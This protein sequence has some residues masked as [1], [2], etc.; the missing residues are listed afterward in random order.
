MK[1]YYWKEKKNFGDLL[2]S[3]LIKHF[4]QLSAV[5]SRPEDAAL[6]MVGS[7]LHHFPKIWKGIVAGSGKL[8]ESTIIPAGA[9]ILA[10]RGPLSA[11]GV[12]HDVGLGDPGL[13]ADEL[14]GYQ[15]KQWEL[16]VVPHWSD[17]VLEYNPTFLK[18]NPKIIRVS[19]DPLDVI[20]QIG[21]CKKIVSSSLHGII[22]ADAFGIPRR[23][24]MAPDV[25][26]NPVEGGLFKWQDYSASINAKLEIGVT[27]EVNRNTVTDRQHEL[28]DV[29]RELKRYFP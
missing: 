20:W 4:L 26:N 10:L 2:S 19:D 15:D 24:E 28:F 12:R 9:R 25:A 1:I 11:K 27:R 29:F 21:A 7:I 5:W 14:V 23:I 17:K 18:Y 16:G 13:L 3:L 6:T 22:L 8:Y